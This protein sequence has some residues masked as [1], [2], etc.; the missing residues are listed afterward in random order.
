MKHKYF[1]LMLIAVILMDALAG[2]EFDLF[3]PSFA[4]IQ[5]YFHITTFWTEALLSINFIGYFISLFVVGTLADHFGRKIVIIYGLLIFLI[6]SL[7]CWFASNYA[8]LLIGRFLQGIGVAAPAI[9]SFL[10]IADRYP[11]KQQQVLMAMLNGSLN[12]AAG[13]APVIG[14]YLTLYFHWRGNFAALFVLGLLTAIATLLTIEKD[15]P[16]NKQATLS[17]KGYAQVFKSKQLMLM[18]GYVVLMATP[19]WIF[20]G[21]SP[22][23]YVKSLHVSLHVFGYYQG[24]LA[25]VFAI[26]SIL[27]GFI[28]SRF[29]QNKWLWIGLWL[30]IV[31]L[32][33]MLYASFVGESS[34]WVITA[35]MLVFVIAQIIPG[36]ILYPLCLNYLPEAKGK[37]AAVQQ[38][39][40]LLFV[41]L[42]LQITGYFYNGSFTMTG[43]IIALF[44]VGIIIT[45]WMIMR[46]KKII[47]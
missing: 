19:Y 38:G 34:P 15:A 31:S 30:F 32:V 41:S 42:V 5:Q 47:Q 4:Q 24:I 10:I 43:S 1:S 12:I 13:V 8:L 36:I 44:L 27:L 33:A 37:I 14:S 29:S 6:G 28:V 9:L 2:M 20:I 23:L 39:S 26:G 22:L 11:I 16:Q 35:A 46:N 25:F 21:I 3:T 17:I 7:C 40:R 18:I 45:Q